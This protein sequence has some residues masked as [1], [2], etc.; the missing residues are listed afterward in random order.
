MEDPSA[1]EQRS[2]EAPQPTSVRPPGLEF[3][4]GTALFAMVLLA[5]FLVQS[6]VFIAGVYSRSPEFVEQGFSFGLLSDSAFRTRMDQLLYTG[7]LVARQALWSGLVG[8]LF[9]LVSVL[10]WKRKNAVDFLGLRVPHFKRFLPWLGL[11]IL[12]ALLIEGLARISPTFRTDFMER[13]IGSTTNLPLLLLGVGIMAPLF[14]ELLL[15]GLLFGSVRYLKD[16][17][18][19]VA[20]TAGV[21]ALMHLQYNWAIML[22][23]IPMGM[24]LGYARSRSG[25]IWVPVLL[26]VLNNSMSVLW[27]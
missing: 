2:A 3:A 21:F 26:H 25:S 11:F 17:H 12:L 16:E 23:I 10:L 14:E 27:S 19:T 20:I 15:R 4:M 1:Q 18:T 24:V 7:D 6:G 9:I 8:S 22:L 13:V 5:F